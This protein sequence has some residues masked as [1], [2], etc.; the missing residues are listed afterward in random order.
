MNTFDHIEEL[1]KLGGFYESIKFSSTFSKSED[2]KKYINNNSFGKFLEGFDSA[3]DRLGIWGE[4]LINNIN[5]SLKLAGYSYSERFFICTLPYINDPAFTYSLPNDDNIIIV[6]C[7]I[8]L[9]LTQLSSSF[10]EYS[11]K[12]I[13]NQNKKQ[14]H[15]QLCVCLREY[16][17][18]FCN[19][20]PRY[21]D[22][23]GIM[24][25]RDVS[26]NEGLYIKDAILT[27]ILLHECSHNF[28]KHTKRHINIF[29]DDGE[30]DY[31]KVMLS[32]EM[33]FEADRLAIQLYFECSKY[34]NDFYLFKA[35]QDYWFA[36]L[37][38]F[39]FLLLK[40]KLINNNKNENILTLHPSPMDR[41]L[42]LEKIIKSKFS[43]SSE[44]NKIFVYAEIFTALYCD[45]IT[46]PSI[47][48]SDIIKLTG[49]IL[50][51]S[52]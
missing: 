40:D 32:K 36:P 27:F 50:L 47:L 33:E 51:L 35:L 21:F 3:P 49:N 11:L 42:A 10:Y 29:N 26:L 15:E 25:C 37:L 30:I 16:F 22:I 38:L 18:V 1:R 12:Q 39:D 8:D 7:T 28:L 17:E 24:N 45:P 48:V 52:K 5:N 23:T 46:M 2:Y 6:N 44:Y 31:E 19:R 34:H 14:I 43:I 20:N 13:L 9:M 4:K 41:K